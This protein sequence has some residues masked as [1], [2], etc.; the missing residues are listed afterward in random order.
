MPSATLQESRRPR[1]TSPGRY[2]R[3]LGFTAGGIATVL[4]VGWLGL[5]VQPSPLPDASITAGQ[6]TTVR[7][8]GGLPA[9]VDRFYRELYGERVPVVDSAV[10]SGRGTMRIA[11][12]TFPARFRFSHVTGESYRHYIELTGFG[13]RLMAVNEWFVDDHARLEL[14]FGVSEGPNIDQGA[15]LA[16]WAE[17]I[18][19]PSVWVTDPKV[20]WEPIDDTSTRLTVPFGDDDETFTVHFDPETGLLTRMQSLRF[21]GAAAEARTGWRNEAPEWG[22]VDGHPV[23]LTAT[24]TWA[25]EGSPWAD[26]RTDEVVYNADL[27][28]YVRGAGP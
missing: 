4:G 18:W 22:R 2:R 12:I 1:S 10:I 28:D 13:A 25:D 11:G 8:P 15:N 7:L 17:A 5:R 27:D 6:V 16:L 21:K 20:R 14:P 3:P 19:M 9:P 23:P 26:L 24:V